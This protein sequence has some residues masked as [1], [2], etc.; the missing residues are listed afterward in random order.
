MRATVNN[1]III[2][3]GLQH[4]I[5]C[6]R[7]KIK[8][9]DRQISRKGVGSI[10]LS[11]CA[12]SFW[13]SCLI[14]LIPTISILKLFRI[15]R[16]CNLE[17]VRIFLVAIFVIYPLVFGRATVAPICWTAVYSVHLVPCSPVFFEI[18][19]FLCF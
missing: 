14:K 17:R 4:L 13:T 12:Q 7:Y 3:V 2:I 19:R 16:I 1:A 18:Q 10:R 6:G 9:F 5:W 15:N 8:K 11:Q